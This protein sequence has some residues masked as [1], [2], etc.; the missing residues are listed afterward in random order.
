MPKRLNAQDQVALVGRELVRDAARWGASWFCISLF[1]KLGIGFPQTRSAPEFLRS[2]SEDGAFP[3]QETI[4]ARRA[5]PA[6]ASW[7]KNSCI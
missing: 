5:A 1:V 3:V 2:T 6:C 7:R 4:T